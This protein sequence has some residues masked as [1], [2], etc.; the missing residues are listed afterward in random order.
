MQAGDLVKTVRASI[1][2]PLN[3]VGLVLSVT[4]GSSE[5]GLSGYSE[6]FVYYDVQLCNNSSR[7][8]RRLERDLEVI[9]ASR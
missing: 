5:G 4:T 7:T 3:S 8:V 1:G 6:K 9:N 2:C